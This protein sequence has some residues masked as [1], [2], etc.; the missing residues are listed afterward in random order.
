MAQIPSHDLVDE[1]SGKTLNSVVFT[2]GTNLFAGL[3]ED[4]ANFPDQ[5]IFM[6]EDGGPQP[7]DRM[8][9]TNSDHEV[10]VVAIV[11][12]KARD[13]KTTVGIAADLRRYLH[14]SVPSGYDIVLADQSIGLRLINDAKERPRYKLTFRARY[15]ETSLP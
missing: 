7:L 2:S 14:G 6:Y 15:E 3:E 8:G 9:N 11:R 10:S 1:A 5:C 12:G 13:E 4:G